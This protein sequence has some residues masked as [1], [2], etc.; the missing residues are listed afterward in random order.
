MRTL[1]MILLLLALLPAVG[2]T[3]DEPLDQVREAYEVAREDSARA[4]RLFAEVVEMLEERAAD[5]LEARYLLGVLHAPLFP[6]HVS[7]R[8]RRD[9]LRGIALL[10]ENAEAGHAPSVAHLGFM[11][12]IRD[13]YETSAS[14]YR[15]A[16]EL[17]LPRAQVMLGQLYAWGQG[18]ERDPERAVFW[19][20]QAMESG[21]DRVRRDAAQTLR[22]DVHNG[23]IPEAVA[24]EAL[25]VAREIG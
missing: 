9:S 15:R 7:F 17:G 6:K 23:L 14:Y 1:S 11:Y 18:V 13:D 5:D 10:T 12:F 4:E 8:L 22:A 24:S 19:L 3:P 16:A 21:D 2:C 20:R 25:E